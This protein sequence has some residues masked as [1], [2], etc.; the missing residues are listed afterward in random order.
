MNY[1]YAIG[2]ALFPGYCPAF[3]VEEKLRR[4]LLLMEDFIN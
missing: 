1:R 2:V 4:R 3:H